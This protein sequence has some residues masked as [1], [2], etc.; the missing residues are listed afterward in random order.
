MV[1]SGSFNV[2]A[3]VYLGAALNV[4]GGVLRVISTI[5]GVICTGTAGYVVAMIGQVLTAA[6]QPFL[7][8][9]PTT[10][11]SIWFGPNERA[12]AT[13][14]SS[15]GKQVRE[16]VY[17]HH[18]LDHPVCSMK[19]FKLALEHLLHF[20]FL[21]ANPVGLAVVQLASAFIVTSAKKVPLMVIF[22]SPCNSAA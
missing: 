7:L 11:A 18:M 17:K 21:I 14:I 12:V 22:F 16:V 10:L 5:E 9:A 2:V 13:G 20:V 8:Y 1:E 15:L 19:S 6:A 3:Q 4:V